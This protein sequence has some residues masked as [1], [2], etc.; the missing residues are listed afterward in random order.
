MTINQ[1][2]ASEG[3]SRQSLGQQIYQLLR[4][5]ILSL[6]L[7]PSAELDEVQI[8]RDFGFSRTP[9]REALIR[10]AGDGLVILAPN[11]GA[12]VAPIDIDQ[13]PQTLEALEL[14]ERVTAR[15]AAQRRRPEHLRQ[16]EERNRAFADACERGEQREIVEANRLFHD[17]INQACGNRYIGADCTKMLS[18]VMRLSLLAF[19]QEKKPKLASNLEVARQHDE[20]IAA[21]RDQD[22][23]RAEQLIFMHS[24]EFRERIKAYVTGESTANIGL[25]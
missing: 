4:E 3:A 23:D 12:R 7:A 22:E 14:L 13:I 1:R 15:W 9:V 16:L 5:Q 21:I 6:E 19:R 11:R 25:S 10:L 8:S 18:G 17:V 24:N 2:A 20:L